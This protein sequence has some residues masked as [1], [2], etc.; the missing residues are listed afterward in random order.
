MSGGHYSLQDSHFFGNSSSSE[1]VLVR[2]MTATWVALIARSRIILNRQYV[3]VHCTKHVWCV[4]LGALLSGRAH[5][6]RVG[7]TVIGPICLYLHASLFSFCHCD[8][9]CL[10]LALALPYSCHLSLHYFSAVIPPFSLWFT[11]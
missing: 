2:G 4:T 9:G 8:P 5:C 1:W 7:R 6:Y 3:P 10:S 11:I